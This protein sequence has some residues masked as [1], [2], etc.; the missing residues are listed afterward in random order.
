MVDEGVEVEARDEATEVVQP[1]D[2]AFDRPAPAVAAQFATVLGGVSFAP[3]TM[4]TDQLDVASGQ[5]FTQRVAVGRAIIDQSAWHVRCDRRVD[6]ALDK[7][8]L[9]MIGCLDVNGQ[10][11]SGTIAEDHDLGALASA[12]LANAIA[13]FFAEAKVPSAKPSSQSIWPRRSSLPSNR[14]NAL[15]SRPSLAHSVNRRQHVGYEG[16]SEGRSFQRAPLMSTHRMPSKHARESTLGRPPWRPGRPV[17]NKS[18]ISD[19]CSSVS[20]QRALLSS[21]SILDPAQPRDRATIEVSF[22]PQVRS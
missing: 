14:R 5:S 16:N 7:V 6:Q 9:G 8:D 2:A 21:G 13:P 10:R 15:S 4:G 3:A 1:T 19:H 17:R 18:E 20:R 12:G 11:Q 22:R